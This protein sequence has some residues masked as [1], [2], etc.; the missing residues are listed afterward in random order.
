MVDH[1]RVPIT[2]KHSTNSA[3][4]AGDI[5]EKKVLLA[6]KTPRVPQIFGHNIGSIHWR[7]ESL[8]WTLM[9]IMFDK[10]L[11]CDAAVTQSWDAA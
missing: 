8:T 1:P 9:L 5:A 6:M 3:G 10:V 4:G 2:Q 11:I 7:D